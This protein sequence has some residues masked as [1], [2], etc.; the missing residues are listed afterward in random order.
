MVEANKNEGNSLNSDF[1]EDSSFSVLSESEF[2][3]LCKV[4]LLL[5]DHNL[6]IVVPSDCK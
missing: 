2:V 1:S 5:G 6:E 3:E 4:V